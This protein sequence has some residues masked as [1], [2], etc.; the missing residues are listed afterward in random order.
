[1]DNSLNFETYLFI[2]KEKFIISVYTNSDERVYEKES[3]VDKQ[4]PND[5][6]FVKLDNFLNQNIFKIEKILN[7]FIKGIILIIESDNFF[8]VDISVKKKNHDN[9][10]NSASIHHL[11]NEARLNCMKTFED[12]KIIHMLIKNYNIDDKY[13]SSL[14]IDI[15]G[16]N[17][18]LD[19]N[20]ICLSN[21]HIKNL[22]KV[23]K[24]YQISLKKILSAFYVQEFFTEE[25]KNLFLISK[26]II[27]GHNLNEVKLIDKTIKN[28]GFFERFFNLFN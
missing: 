19:I 16:K 10:L 8:S 26:K 2:S 13:Y 17:F 9:F 12:R 28:R 11:L 3:I 22:E 24:N 27:N 14:P 20:F 6:F 7:D 1:M 15:K 23:L 25:E 5:V 4:I 21:N 18:S